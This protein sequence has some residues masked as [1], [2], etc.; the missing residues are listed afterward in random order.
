MLGAKSLCNQQTLLKEISIN[1]EQYIEF[2]VSFWEFIQLNLI[3]KYLSVHYV[4]GSLLDSG[5]TASLTFLSYL[6]VILFFL[7]F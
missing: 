2:T 7:I 1:R 5:K 4:L 3:H 6:M